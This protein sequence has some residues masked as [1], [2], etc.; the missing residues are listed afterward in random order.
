MIDISVWPIQT[1]RMALHYGAKFDVAIT[2]LDTHTKKI[3][4]EKHVFW[5]IPVIQ[6][7]FYDYSH[8]Q[9]RGA[10]T[11]KQV[12]NI[13]KAVTQYVSS[14]SRIAVACMAGRSRSSAVALSILS[15]AHENNNAAIQHLRN[16]PRSDEFL[17]NSLIVRYAD[18][19]IGHNGNLLETMYQSYYDQDPS[20]LHRSEHPWKA[21]RVQAE[22]F[23][24]RP[25]SK[26]AGDIDEKVCKQANCP[27]CG[28]VG[29]DYQPYYDPDTNK[30][31]AYAVCPTCGYQNEF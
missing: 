29:L 23:L 7:W 6:E 5:G 24:R 13:L 1:L 11:P 4:G 28:H 12:Q 30:Y 16:L 27:D 3:Y 19:F 14:S 21:F 2:T 9:D 31:I 22:G 8:P 17:P 25:P 20:E 15:M 26:I 10:P 18:Q